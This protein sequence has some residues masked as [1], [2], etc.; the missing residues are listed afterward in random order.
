MSVNFD[1]AYTLIEYHLL[2]SE[3][4]PFHG[5]TGGAGSSERRMG[6]KRRLGLDFAGSYRLC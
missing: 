3:M 4:N 2:S 6:C 5:M 1:G